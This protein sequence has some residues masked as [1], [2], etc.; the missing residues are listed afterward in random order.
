MKI[1][2]WNVNGI[3]SCVRQGFVSWLRRCGADVVA[4]QEVRA[5]TE[6]LPAELRRLR[7]WHLHLA[8]ANK[9][10]YS[11]VA[12]LSRAAPDDVKI[13]MGRPEFDDEGRLLRARFGSTVVVN[14]YFP[15]GNGKNYDLSR[16]PYKLD[17]TRAVREW[18]ARDAAADHATVVVGDFNT[19]H[20]EIDLARPK[21]NVK[22]SGFRPEERA[23]F[24][25]WLRAGWTDTWRSRHPE[26]IVY[27]WWSQRSGCRA[28][29]VGWRLDYV[30]ANSAAMARLK[31]VQIHTKV[32]GSDHCPVSAVLE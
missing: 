28:R 32:K 29:N 11:G 25:R 19:A 30:L 20:R 27:S 18:C 16:L 10:G 21:A 5:T 13:G 7:S 15:S 8:P 17:Y 1:V 6:N 31:E 12:L 23:E 2:T 4:L 14:S 9:P 22:N 24:D 26:R 3:R